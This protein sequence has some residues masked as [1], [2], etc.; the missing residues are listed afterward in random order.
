MRTLE[1]IRDVELNYCWASYAA[2]YNEI[3]KNETR[4]F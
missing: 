1:V 3:K 4:H 2:S